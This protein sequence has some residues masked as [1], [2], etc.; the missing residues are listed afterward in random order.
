MMLIRM[1]MCSVTLVT[2]EFSESDPSLTGR[3]LE[4]RV[5]GDH[6]VSVFLP[7]GAEGGEAG[8][9]SLKNSPA[10]RDRCAI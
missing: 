4:L 5:F 1:M 7:C 6:Y 8:K 10:N 9:L 3:P 2:D